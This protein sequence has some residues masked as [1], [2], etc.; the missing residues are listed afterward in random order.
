MAAGLALRVTEGKEEMYGLE[1]SFGGVSVTWLV[2]SP[3]GVG[4][5]HRAVS[6]EP[7]PAPSNMCIQGL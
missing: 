4:G 6:R 3:S 2:I 5:W 7:F 1:N